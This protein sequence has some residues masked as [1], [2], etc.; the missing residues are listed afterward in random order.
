MKK[1]MIIGA[2]ALIIFSG[3]ISLGTQTEPA[4][5]RQSLETSMPSAYIDTIGEDIQL[6]VPKSTPSTTPEATPTPMATPEATPKPTPKAT[7]KP[8]PKATPKATPKP[9]PK[10]PAATPQ[11]TSPKALAIINTA[12][13]YQGVPYVWGG[14]TPDGFDCSGFIQYVFNKNGISLPR[15]TSDQYKVGTS[16]SKSNLIPGDLVFFE[17]YKPGASHVGIY[18]GNNQFIHASS[19]KNKVMISSLTSTYY[20][21]HYIGSRRV[22]K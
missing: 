22:I 12:K 15:V 7:P 3:I 19:G 10:A 14:T 21:E 18:I 4:E 8:T 6:M 1:Y 11:A 20:T 5:A 16:V 9:T 13:S 17:T 2:S